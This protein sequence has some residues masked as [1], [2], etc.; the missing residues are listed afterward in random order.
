M[1]SPEAFYLNYMANN[2]GFRATWDPAR[3]L[4]MGYIGQLDEAGFFTVYSSLEKEGIP[5]DTIE[6][7]STG[8]M[9]YTSHD[10][11]NVQIKLA[12]SA[13]V[14]GSVLSNADAGVTIEFGSSNGIVFQTT[15][16]KTLQLDNL[17]TVRKLVLDKYNS[18]NWDKDWLIITH[19]VLCDS[20]TAIISN[21]SSGKLELKAKAGVAAGDIK[22]TDASL[23]L[24][25]AR[26]SGSTMKFIAQAGATPLYRV[27]GIRHPLF[28]KAD[29]QPKSLRGGDVQQENFAIQDFD[30]AELDQ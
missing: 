27:M 30:P 2:T 5:N 24:T 12:G 7:D 21:S 20:V 10:S 29:L 13:P 1:I 19:L 28:G 4:K 3:P 16:Y 14:A 8:E 6:D 18:G 25:T 11:V 17:S 15:K 23:G 22:L 26:E 9:D